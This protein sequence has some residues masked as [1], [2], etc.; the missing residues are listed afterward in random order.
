M[1]KYK[2]SAEHGTPD[3]V[4]QVSFP[5]ILGN[6]ARLQADPGPSPPIPL[7]LTPRALWDH[8]AM[9]IRIQDV[10]QPALPPTPV[11]NYV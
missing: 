7:F 4:C 5:R 1:R 10:L 8:G 2:E 6:V 3:G 11:L 9:T